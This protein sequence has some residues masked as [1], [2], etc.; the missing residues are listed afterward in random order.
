MA[1]LDCEEYGGGV[2]EYHWAWIQIL[3]AGDVDLHSSQEGPSSMESASGWVN[4][5]AKKIKREQKRRK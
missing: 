4:P 3:G 5:P 1:E 2:A